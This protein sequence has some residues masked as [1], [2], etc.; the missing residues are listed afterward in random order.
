MVRECH[1]LP[2]GEGL[3][4]ADQRYERRKMT[5]FAALLAHGVT[6]ARARRRP[7]STATPPLLILACHRRLPHSSTSMTSLGAMIFASCAPLISLVFLGG[8][9]GKF[10][11]KPF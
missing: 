7:I 10:A 11:G 3:R 4:R 1:R 6:N 2:G 8:S 9:A 5:L